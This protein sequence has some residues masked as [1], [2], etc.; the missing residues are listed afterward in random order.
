MFPDSLLGFNYKHWEKSQHMPKHAAKSQDDSASNVWDDL[1]F[2]V[3]PTA[4]AYRTFGCFKQWRFS[5][6]SS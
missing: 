2:Q 1:Q 4:D 3:D 5:R 6:F